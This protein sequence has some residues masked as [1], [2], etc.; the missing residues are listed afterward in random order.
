MPGAKFGGVKGVPSIG[1]LRTID[2]Y[3][4]APQS[5]FQSVSRKSY[6]KLYNSEAL[7]MPGFEK[8][9]PKDHFVRMNK[10][11]DGVSIPSSRKDTSQLMI[12]ISP[13]KSRLQAKYVKDEYRKSIINS[14]SP[15]PKKSGSIGHS[16]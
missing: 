5:M 16:N 7:K 13:C 6:E 12:K 14:N 11:S 3:T 10:Y 4:G 9:T 1:P 2:K 8:Y 15:A